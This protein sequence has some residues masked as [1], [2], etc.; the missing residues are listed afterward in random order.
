MGI[1]WSI[2]NWGEVSQ[3]A[4]VFVVVLIALAGVVLTVIT[5]PGTWIAIAGWLLVCLWRNEFFSWWVLAAVLFLAVVGEVI[6]FFASAV[7]AAKGGASR[8]GGIGACIGSI[9]G[10]LVGTPIFFPIGAIAGGVVGAAAG[11]II[12]ERGM[13]EK[14]W[15]ESTKAGAGAAIGRF[16]ATIFKT[17]CAGLI[18]MCF[19]VYVFIKSAF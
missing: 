17:C 2:I 16:A 6:E 5:L 1:D 10:A 11:A 15:K 3:W 4:A 9:V 7:G 8:K 19:G 13:A 14:T 12:A 18:A